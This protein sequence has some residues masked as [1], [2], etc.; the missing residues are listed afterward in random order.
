VNDDSTE[1]IV[2]EI[3]SD[4]AV[5]GAAKGNAALDA[6]GKK[7]DEI[8]AKIGKAAEAQG[9]LV[10]RTS[11][12]S[13]N[14]VERLILSYEKMNATFGQSPMEKV[15]AD[16]DRLVGRLKN[17]TGAIDRANE[18]FAKRVSAM[19]AATAASERE[20][21]AAEKAALAKRK[22][23][24]TARIVEAAETR[25]ATFGKSGVYLLEAQRQLAIKSLNGEAAAIA[26]VNKEF[27]E[28]IALENAAGSG[29]GH[30]S[31]SP[32]ALALRGVRDLFEGR[33]AY[34]EV[35]IG[36]G[37][38]GAGGA[39]AAVGG[40]TLALGGLAIASFKSAEALGETGMQIR[41]VQERTGFSAR[42]VA[43]F[44]FAAKLSGEDVTIF[45][46]AMRGTTQAIEDQ[47]SAGDKARGWLTRFGVDLRGVREGTVS[48]AEVMKQIGEGFKSLPAGVERT[49]AELD[50][51]KKI[52][53]EATP[54]FVEL[55]DRLEKASH[56]KFAVTTNEDVAAFVAIH[57]RMA[58]IGTAW[59]QL[60]LKIEKGLSIPVSFILAAIVDSL[61]RGEPTSEPS[62]L[63]G[64]E[65]RPGHL[66]YG[67]RFYTQ[68]QMD[69]YWEPGPA[70][71][72]RRRLAESLGGVAPPRHLPPEPF[73]DGMKADARAE[74]LRIANATS[75]AAVKSYFARQGAQGRLTADEKALSNLGVID[76]YSTAAQVAAHQ[77]A[78]RKVADDKA[79]VKVLHEKESVL[80]DLRK[81]Q[82]EATDRAAHPFGMLPADKQLME[83]AKKPSVGPEDVAQAR[84]T[85]APQLL[86]EF[87]EKLRKAGLRR[88]LGPE[89]SFIV[90][91]D[92]Q[93]VEEK[94]GHAAE[95]Q[96]EGHEFEQLLKRQG[97]DDREALRPLL[98][99]Q[100]ELRKNTEA[101]ALRSV[102]EDYALL[103]STVQTRLAAESR[104]AK[105]RMDA[106]DEEQHDAINK[107]AQ[108]FT[109]QENYDNDLTA[110]R[111][112][113]EGEVAAA[114]EQYQQ[115]YLQ[116]IRKQLDEIKGPAEGLFHTLFT[117]PKN[118]NKQ[119]SS[120]LK[121][122]A[123]KPIEGGLG[124]MT[125][126][127][128]HPAIFGKDGTGGISGALHGIFGSGGKGIG[129]VQLV[130]GAV[131]VVIQGYFPLPGGGTNDAGPP[132]GVL[133]YP[134]RA[135]KLFGSEG[136]GDTSSFGPKEDW[137]VP[138]FVLGS[139]GW[140]V[141]TGTRGGGEIPGTGDSTTGLERLSS[142]LLRRGPQTTYSGDSWSNPWSP[143]AWNNPA[144]QPGMP[145]G[146]PGFAG[147]VG[148]GP[149]GRG[150]PFGGILGTLK[151][152]FKGVDWGGFTRGEDVGPGQGIPGT[153]GNAGTDLGANGQITGVHGLAGAGLQMGGMYLAQRGLLG[154]DRG[155]AKGTFEGAVGGAAVG[156]QMGGPIGAAIGG[157]VG[158]LAGI[159]E[160]IAGV[161]TPEREASRLIQLI[162]GIHMDYTSGTINQ[163]VA[164]AKQSYGGSVSMAVRSP[165][166][167]DLIKLYADS[168]GQKSALLTATQVHSASLMQSG[169]TL[170]QSATY[171]NGTPYTYA[172]P[173]PTLGP[174]GSTIPTGNPLASGAVSH[175]YLNPQQ[176]T[177]LITSGATAAM[178]GN[179]RGVANSAVNGYGQSSSRLNT[180]GLVNDPAVIWS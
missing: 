162:Y 122:A 180:A 43:Q 90:R 46:R 54:V 52:G 53:I 136:Y 163:I 68:A 124:E 55:T 168:T 62:V 18:S 131:P 57:E 38:A 33:T 178:A 177:D 10:V 153:D 143:E 87:D 59:D 69:A 42:E 76:Q 150:S 25:A 75:D 108:E 96:A 60:K 40:L 152:G 73:D 85:L 134:A 129:E 1:Q 140:G 113:H 19:N 64:G 83:F 93:V 35:M 128:L 27:I 118:F 105:I 142:G 95:M 166:V 51:L 148:S 17:E 29:G 63:V 171:S 156:F 15:I 123:L 23:A 160:M 159:G 99:M 141:G 102:K 106:A 173:L 30:G 5:Q 70:G 117:N 26:K 139:V 20:A 36:R 44:G 116:E 175:I 101:S 147:P 135:A 78:E 37:L 161:E 80:E 172:S 13:R 16:H 169:G 145:G 146:T 144:M 107:I 72:K 49:K 79:E 98:L 2:I 91:D 61:N 41:N 121:D 149:G 115:Q 157:G 74:E 104:I 89:A 56:I 21:A 130:N 120:T 84:A 67:G 167:R 77:K 126:K 164:M 111:L 97:A 154:A 6:I 31:G 132:P 151:G 125:A 39:M 88:G 165:Q 47:S 11:D 103:P 65:H 133:P 170:F 34:G 109:T 174:S 114:R 8:T 155:T 81:L 58:T 32:G 50:L 158:L 71:D 110:I 94:T 28:M 138:P 137:G 100:S 179:P 119:L 48:T 9:G 24:D 176:T 86:T 12:K 66:A 14:S 127:L 22:A 45:E 112:K 7:A 92:K 82:V 3:D 4:P